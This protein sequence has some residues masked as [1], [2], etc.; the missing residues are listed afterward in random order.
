MLLFSRTSMIGKK[1]QKITFSIII[2]SLIVGFFPSDTFALVA[3]WTDQTGGHSAG[4]LVSLAANVDGTKL[5]AGEGGTTAG[6]LWTSTNSGVTWTQR[7][8]PALTNGNWQ[9]A[10]ISSDGTIMAAVDATAE[11]GTTGRVWTSIDSGATFL[12]QTGVSLGV[13]DEVA[14][15]VNAGTI[16]VVATANNSGDIWIGTCTSSCSTTGG[17]TW[18]DQTSPAGIH[19]KTWRGV[20]IDSTGTKIVAVINSGDIWTGTYSGSWSWTDQTVAGSRAWLGVTMSS[21]ASKIAATVNGGDVWT[22]QAVGTGSCSSS[23]TGYCWTDQSGGGS[24]P[25]FHIAGSANGT[26]L[27]AASSASGTASLWVSNDSGV[28]WLAQPGAGTKNWRD[29]AMDSVG[30]NMYAADNGAPGAAD[31]WSG[32]SPLIAKTVL[33]APSTTYTTTN[34]FSATGFSGGLVKLFSTKPGTAWTIAPAVTANNTVSFADVQDSSCSSTGST[35]VINA[36]SSTN[37]GNNS[38]VST[39]CWN[40]NIPYMNLTLSSN[41]VDFGTLPLGTP[42]YG[43]NGTLSGGGISDTTS[44]AHTISVATSGS[45]GYNLFVQGD[46]PTGNA[47]IFNAIGSTNTLPASFTT[48]EEFGIRLTVESGGLG[49]AAPGPSG[50]PATVSDY[51]GTGSG[52]AYNAT[53][54][55]PDI[56]GI[57]AGSGLG[58]TVYD[59][60][61]VAYAVG[62]TP[63]A[64][65]S[66]NL[67]YVVVGNY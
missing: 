56:V 22:A 62:S 14:M 30:Q 39:G 6:K 50:S 12:K 63:Q 19:N 9:G 54:A 16:T 33:F 58:T 48:T 51:G 53:A 61:Y 29:V 24:K 1:I 3:I 55:S 46:P 26:R 31:I 10:A 45:G 59:V 7:T 37:D 15:T 52:F 21:D 65:Y 11:S 66:T 4:G 35:T 42:R 44:G 18:S 23:A 38:L 20:A 64:S 67:T 27:L 57:Y 17:W 25:W 47:H 32:Y 13:Y 36:T 34:S 40:F 8:T 60:H 43:T 28:S 5:I 49:I 2:V 41:A